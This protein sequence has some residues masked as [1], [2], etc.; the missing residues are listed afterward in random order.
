MTRSRLT[1]W[2]PEQDLSVLLD[3]LTEELLAVADR[4]L[5]AGIGKEQQD[6]V[7][8]MR[9]LIAAADTDLVVPPAS[10]FAGRT[11]RAFVARNH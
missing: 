8:D 10:N 5:T 7:R 11:L 9:R 3:A 2:N 6:V 1:D 4:D